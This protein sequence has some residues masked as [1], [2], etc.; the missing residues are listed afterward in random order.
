MSVLKAELH[1]GDV[2][3]D[4]TAWHVHGQSWQIAADG[5][6][7][8]IQGISALLDAGKE[9][10]ACLL[11]GRRRVEQRSQGPLHNSPPHLWAQGKCAHWTNQIQV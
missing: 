3:L 7:K 2:L 8:G 4:H 6:W 10:P 11:A 5:S 1:G 9:R